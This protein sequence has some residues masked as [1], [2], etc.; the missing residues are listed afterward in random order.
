MTTPG[1]LAR[2]HSLDAARGILMML[3]ILLHTSN[4][5]STEASWIVSDAE[6]HPI[7]DFFANAI[8]V[9]RMPAFFWISG[10]FCAL[11]FQ[12]NGAT[13]LITKR[14]PRLAIPLLVTWL[15]LNVLQEFALAN[16]NGQDPIKSV[17]DGVP[18][19]HLWF[20]FDLILYVGL[21]ALLMPW[22]SHL[23]TPWHKLDRIPLPLLLV[24]LASLSLLASEI[25]RATGIAYIN[26]YGLTSLYRL[27]TYAPFFAA[28]MVM[29]FQPAVRARF[30]GTPMVLALFA[31]PIALIVKPFE[32]GYGFAIGEGALF[33]ELLMIWI[34][35]G[36]ALHIF[37]RVFQSDSWL[38]RFL[39]DAS[40]S[41]FLFHHVF[42]VFLGVI[43]TRIALGPGT[44]FV[45]ISSVTL[46][47][48]IAIHLLLI[49]RYTILSL[50]FNGKPPTAFARA[51][52]ASAVRS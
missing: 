23:N 2:N 40:Y 34:C 22:L 15:S 36:A 32:K 3:G 10:Y 46:A 4:I 12:K 25:A 35:I 24:G 1:G 17:L 9:F 5:Y 19:Y 33:V 44:K 38:T 31:I 43:F 47:I 41:I 20:L 48:T 13:G 26:A 21:A 18:L 7:F 50:A 16:I 27:A 52:P 37:H 51:Q 42:V 45:I 39:S 11:T 49:H 28:G 6:R 29:Y 14:F 8:H 30:L